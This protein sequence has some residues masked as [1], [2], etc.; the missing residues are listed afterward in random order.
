M[1]FAQQHKKPLEALLN[2]EEPGWPLVLEWISSA[3]NP[4]EILPADTARAGATLYELQVTTRSPMGAI[5]YSSGGI[6]ID[7]GWIRI[8]GSGHDRLNRTLHSWNQGKNPAEFLLVADD[9]V[10]GFFAINSG[11]LGE[12]MGKIYYFDPA[13]LNWEGLDISYSQ[14]LNFCFEGDLKDFYKDLRWSNWQQEVA[15]L[16][17]NE[18][19]NFFPMLWTKEGKDING[20]SRKKVPVE[21]QYGINME[22][23]KQLG[24]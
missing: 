21:E 24:R 6:L 3:T 23:R 7:H 10:G 11:A 4:V 20:V 13:T 14:F 18:V 8:L 5:V 15:T 17:G 12:D 2:K 16:D 22:L 9:A 19:F 1:T